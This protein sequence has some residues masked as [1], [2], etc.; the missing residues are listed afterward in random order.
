VR[1]F[2]RY[3]PSGVREVR[4]ARL[5]VDLARQNID[6]FLMPVYLRETILQGFRYVPIAVQ[7]GLT[8]DEPLCLFS[9]T[10]SPFLMRIL[11]LVV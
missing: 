1:R 5:P 6:H 4:T 11:R 2:I 7:Y 9:F 8:A 3:S 10:R